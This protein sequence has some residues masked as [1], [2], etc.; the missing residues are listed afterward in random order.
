MK[1]TII[2]LAALLPC[3]AFAQIVYPGT[4]QAAPDLVPIQLE[5][6]R[7]NQQLQIM[8]QTQAK[9]ARSYV[10]G[11]TPAQR[12]ARRAQ[13]LV[14]AEAAYKADWQA[15]NP[16][17]PSFRAPPF[18][19][20]FADQALADSDAQA[21]ANA[22]RIQVVQAAPRPVAQNPAQITAMQRRIK[23]LE[24]QLAAAKK[25]AQAPTK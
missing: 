9:P 1:T 8:Q 15:K 17:L 16:L 19:K 10:P 23:Q 22:Q 20:Q 21:A 18:Y 11:E 25:K 13:A 4:V 6:S 5:L 24:A 14:D 12:D 3:C 2:L 7:L